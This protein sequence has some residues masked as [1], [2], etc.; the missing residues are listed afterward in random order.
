MGRDAL[1]KQGAPF[2]WWSYLSG[3]VARAETV[4][5]KSTFRDSFLR[6]RCLIPASDL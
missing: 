6:N 5:T 1:Q 4:D 2:C 3:S